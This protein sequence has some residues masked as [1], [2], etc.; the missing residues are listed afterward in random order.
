MTKGNHVNLAI[1]ND[2][3]DE[4]ADDVS[5]GDSLEVGDNPERSAQANENA[6]QLRA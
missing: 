2:D 5:V 3:E 1:R 6:R 4:E